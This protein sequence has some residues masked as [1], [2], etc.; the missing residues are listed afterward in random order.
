MFFLKD[1]QT[2]KSKQIGLL[3][4]NLGTPDS[5]KPKDVYR[6]LIE[7]LTDSRVIDLSWLRR[8]LLVRGII[9]PA[10]YKQSAKSYQAIW[11]S[12][13][14]PL[15]FYSQ[16]VKDLLQKALPANYSVEIAMRYQN[17]SI[18][19]GLESLM[20]KNLDELI[21]LPLFPQYASA[22]TGSIYQRVMELLSKYL[23]IPKVTLINQFA[24]HPSYIEAVCTVAKKYQIEDYDHVLFSF[25]GLPQRQLRKAD[26]HQRCTQSTTCCQQLNSYNKDCYAA[27]CYATANAIASSLKL[28]KYTV[29]FQ[30][31]L[32]KEPWIEPYASDCI[33]SLAE[34]GNKRVL[35]FCPSFVADCLETIHEIGV[36]YAAEFSHA[37]GEHLDYVESL[38]DH[39][40][41][42]KALQDITN[43]K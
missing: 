21:V 34:K 15:L 33:K 5:P 35:V 9:V 40:Q 11:T 43:C 19:S 22:T 12:E 3:L 20:K 29:C 4:V 7:F 1:M 25:H 14:S 27:Q 2:D 41:W 8:Q 36:E 28:E 31:R 32:G 18:A 26:C 6:Y 30:S 38:N 13:G 17:P 42:V 24:T 39:P 10:R 23:T 16:R 37:G